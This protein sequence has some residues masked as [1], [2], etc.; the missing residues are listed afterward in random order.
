MSIQIFL[1][2]WF[3]YLDLAGTWNLHCRPWLPSK[4]QTFFCFSLLSALIK[5][6]YHPTWLT[7]IFED[8]Y[9]SVCNSEP[10]VD[11]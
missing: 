1:K 9:T 2:T 5:G 8:K 11:Y 6:M 4:L 7:Q 3:N 10:A